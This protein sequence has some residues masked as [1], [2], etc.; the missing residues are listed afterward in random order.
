MNREDI[1]RPTGSLLPVLVLMGLRGSGKTSL[2]KA[3]ELRTGAACIDLD[4]RTRAAM[5]VATVAEAFASQG[6]AAF[7][8]AEVEALRAAFDELRPGEGRGE[9]APAEGI[10]ALGG[11]T[12]T[13]EGAVGVLRQAQSAGRGLLVYL[14]ATPE[15]LRSR[16]AA[17]DADRPSLTGADTVAEI[18]AVFAQRDPLYRRLADAEVAVDGLTESEA[19]EEVLRLWRRTSPGRDGGAQHR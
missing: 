19:A 12:P 2:C 18:E 7:R 13:A 5:G 1:T 11:G 17:P 6:Q 4:D 15:T 9:P 3:L 14:R 16:L 8:A 10:I